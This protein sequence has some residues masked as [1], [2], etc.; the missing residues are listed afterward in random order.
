MSTE[1]TGIANA[2]SDV[3][4]HEFSYHSP[5]SKGIVRVIAEDETTFEKGL[6]TV[7]DEVAQT[8]DRIKV[9]S[10]GKRKFLDT[11]RSEF[12]HWSKSLYRYFR[13]EFF[14]FEKSS[15][16]NLVKKVLSEHYR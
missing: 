14:N 5:S 9:Y 1:I 16:I 7:G 10:G 11:S 4:L 2:Y 12:I 8:S 3:G 15:S 6:R 13:D